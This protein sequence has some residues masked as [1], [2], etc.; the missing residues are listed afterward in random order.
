MN[1]YLFKAS[2]DNYFEID[3]NMELVTYPAV[4][5]VNWNLPS[6]Q[7]LASHYC[8]C[9]TS[10]TETSSRI[11][12]CMTHIA[13]CNHEGSNNS[14][15]SS[16]TE[17]IKENLYMDNFRKNS[18]NCGS[19]TAKIDE[20][21]TSSIMK[22]TQSK[23]KSPHDMVNYE[24]LKGHKYEIRPNPNKGEKNARIFV[25]KYDNCN[26]VFS[27]TWNLVYHFRVHT[28]EKPFVCEK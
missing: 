1:T 10:G 22:S 3:T 4:P 28:K 6:L 17:E 12:D 19:G 21:C 9:G 16:T 25:C 14:G 8:L 2:E 20:H 23:K 5:Q 13:C 26:K 18:H 11:P 27:K 15:S 7:A 24:V